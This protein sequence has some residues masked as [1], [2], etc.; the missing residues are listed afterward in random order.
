MRIPWHSWT[1]S[2]SLHLPDDLSRHGRVKIDC[3]VSQALRGLVTLAT[4]TL[5]G[6]ADADLCSVAILGMVL[7]AID[8][9]ISLFTSWNWT[10]ERL[11]VTAIHTHRAEDGL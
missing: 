11:L 7:N 2:P 9:L 3:M 5:E 8:V 1:S 10:C 6:F 4:T